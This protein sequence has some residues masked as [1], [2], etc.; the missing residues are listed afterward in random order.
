MVQQRGVCNGCQGE[1]DAACKGPDVGETQVNLVSP[2]LHGNGGT[3]RRER[4]EEK[5]E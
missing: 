3:V 1:A 4:I 2:Y 5:A